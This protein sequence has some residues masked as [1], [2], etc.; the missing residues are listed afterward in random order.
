MMYLI[1]GFGSIAVGLAYT[2]LGALSAWETIS[3]HRYRGWSRFGMGF[4]LMAASC[5]PHH[6]VHGWHVL[7]GESVSWPMLAATLIGLP[8]GVTFVLL[9][10]ETLWGGQGERMIAARPHHAAL[11]GGAFSIVAGWLAASALAQPGADFPFPVICIS[12]AN[13]AAAQATAI[14]FTSVTFL[15]NMFVAVTYGMVGIYLADHQMR[16]YLSVGAWSL[17]GSALTGVFFTCS[18]MHIID[19]TTHDNSVMLAFDLI[20]IPASIYFLRVVRQ[21]HTDAVLDWNRRPLVGAAA[22]PARQSPWS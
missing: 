4:S 13:A 11:L 20:G 17:S 3:L 1:I 15:A 12:V 22:A 5:G 2:G 6:F 18:L 7:Q 8:A 19:A 10:F 21:V 16:R 14:D 9:R